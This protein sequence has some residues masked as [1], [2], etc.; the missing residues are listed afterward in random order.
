MTHLY[1]IIAAAF[2]GYGG[3]ML[4]EM[5]P[6]L[7]GRANGNAPNGYAPIEIACP[8]QRPV[9]RSADALSSNESTWLGQRVG[10]IHSAL[11]PLLERADIGDIDVRAYLQ[12]ITDH[13]GTLPRIG[14]AV[15]GGGYRAL[16]N[17]A[18]ALAAFDDRTSG[19]TETGRLGG[20]LQAST[21]VS[22]LSGGSWLVGSL[23]MANFTTVESIVGAT[24][25]FLSQ[26]WQFDETI[27]EGPATLSARDYYQQL[28]DAVDAKANAGYHITITD[29]WGRALSYQLFNAIDGSPAYTLSSVAADPAFSTAAIPMPIIVALERP[30]GQIR[31]W[32]NAT[33][34]EFNP[35]EMGSYDP[36]NP[37]FAPLRYVGSAFD[38]GTLARGAPCV[39]GVDNIGFVVGTSSSLFN[40]AFLQLGRASPDGVVPEFFLRSLNETLARISEENTDVASWPNPFFHYRP[41]DNRNANTSTLDLVDGGEDLQNI[42]LHP[43]LWSRR[44]VD[45]ILAV[46]SSADTTTHW[47]NGTALVAT[48]RRATSGYYA[49]PETDRFPLVPGQNTFVNLGLN[50][51]PTFFGCRPDPDDTGAPGPLIVYLPNAP[52]SAYS[53]VSTVQ[54]EY[55]HEEWRAIMRNGYDAVTMANATLDAQWPAC[56][57][58][59]ILERSLRRTGTPFP[60]A[61]NDCFARYCWDGMMNETTPSS[62]YS[63]TQMVVSSGVEGGMV[64]SFAQGLH[65][66]SVVWGLVVYGGWL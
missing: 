46:D 7:N 11:I 35:W 4:L 45:V 47:P 40:Q 26:L 32:D 8:A 29:S 57:G 36:G 28:Q 54:M 24:E 62:E 63:P 44:A 58:C 42:P 31:I 3:S 33:V 53:N 39:A 34:F 41:A 25:G 12:D 27:I 13:S 22:G 23:Y 18:G 30:S 61:C 2:A 10:A 19:S 55:T 50:R 1:A 20:I 65:V 9:V 51:R 5:V 16:M 15:S 59:A 66:A 17:G 14:I 52:Y 60:A 48:Y 6:P 64:L 56:L 49:P 37:A 43:L 38:N 21:Y